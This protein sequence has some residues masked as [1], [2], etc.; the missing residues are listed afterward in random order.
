[1]L[2]EDC[3]GGLATRRL[4]LPLVERSR[5]LIYTNYNRYCEGRITCPEFIEG[6]EAICQPKKIAALVPHSQ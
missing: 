5:N 3:S 6:A 4:E 2:V 1:V